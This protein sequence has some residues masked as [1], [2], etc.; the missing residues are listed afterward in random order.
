MKLKISP[1]PVAIGPSSGSSPGG[2]LARASCRRSVD[3]LAREVDVG[4][5]LEHDGDLR[6][7]VARDRARVVEPRQARHRR[8][9]RERDALLG[10][11]RRIAGR[12]RVDLHLHVGDVG[13]GVDRAGADSCRRRTPRARRRRAA[14]ASGAGRS[15]RRDSR[16]CAFS[17][18]VVVA[19][20]GL[21]DVGLDE[22]AVLGHV[23]RARREPVEHLDE[24]RVAAAER[25]A[26]A[27]RRCR[28]PGRTRRRTRGSAAAPRAARRARRASS[29][30]VTRP[31]TNWPGV[32]RPSALSRTTR[33]V[34][35][36]DARLPTGAR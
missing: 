16:A 25:R 11:E 31:S 8:L 14:R 32:Q 24:A 4:A 15:E 21:F 20:A 27:P 33:A 23:G 9:D 19:R 18:S 12:L 6:Q 1:R 28:R 13:N 30:I 2:K 17:A 26:C 3:A 10:L 22:V 7:P 35:L 34:T 29:P 5:V 36:C